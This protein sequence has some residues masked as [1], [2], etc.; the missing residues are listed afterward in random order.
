MS[1]ASL[2]SVLRQR[3]VTC[4]TCLTFGVHFSAFSP[5]T[6]LFDSNRAENQCARG[7]GG[8]KGLEGEIRMNRPGIQCVGLA[9]ALLAS[10]TAT[11]ATSTHKA[12]NTVI[13]SGN[14][15]AA[16]PAGTGTGIDAATIVNC[17]TVNGCTLGIDAMVHIYFGLHFNR[18]AICAT[19]DSGTVPPCPLN[20]QRDFDFG[21]DAGNQL[22]N[23][24]VTPGNHTVQTY[25]VPSQA[26]TLQNWEVHYTMYKP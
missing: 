15:G 9:L 22:L 3:T 23:I 13:N 6:T 4:L 14:G 17:P 1:V 12:I 26:A 8:A 18:W 24:H 21:Y 20:Q 16:L 11:A 7:S 2:A 19:V 10:N 25:V 5:F